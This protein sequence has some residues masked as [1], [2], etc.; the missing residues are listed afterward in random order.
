MSFGLNVLILDSRAMT[1]CALLNYSIVRTIARSDT[2]AHVAECHD[3][4]EY[5][6]MMS[7]MP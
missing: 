7:E 6:L 2:D 4:M 3:V 5:V 1:Y